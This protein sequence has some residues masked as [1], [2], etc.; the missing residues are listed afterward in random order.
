L[1][2][3]IIDIYKLREIVITMGLF[4]WSNNHL[5]PTLEKLDGVLVSK[6]WEDP[7]AMGQK[8]VRYCSD[9]S[10]LILSLNNEQSKPTSTFRCDFFLEE[11]DRLL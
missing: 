9:H 5:K 8:V 11:R 4:T 10:P 1:F 6:G 2:N 3:S 7:L